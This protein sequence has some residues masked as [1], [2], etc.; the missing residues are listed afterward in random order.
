M[1][2]DDD[3]GVVASRQLGRRRASHLVAVADVH[4]KALD[5]HDDFPAQLRIAG[6][7]GVAEYSLDRRDQSELVQNPG[8]ADI[9]GVE[10]EL[11]SR[12]R[13]VDAGSEKPMRIGDE[14]YD[15]RFGS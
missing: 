12:Q 4:P 3:I 9:S 2:K 1:T 14:S 6:R 5:C 15:V 7:V 8:P 10:N 11:D 13:F